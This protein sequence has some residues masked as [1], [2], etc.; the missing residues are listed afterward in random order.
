MRFTRRC[1]LIATAIILIL[2][3]G[4]WL[5]PL[6]FIGRMAWW[7]LV[8][9]TIA[10]FFLLYK[11]KRMVNGHRE[12][13]DRFS[14]GDENQVTLS[15]ESNFSRPLHLEVI[16]EIPVQFQRHDICFY[17]D[18][19]PRGQAVI[20]YQLRPTTRGVYGFGHIR[21]FAMTRLHLVQRRFTCGEPKDIKVYPSYL[22][23]HQYELLAMSNNLHEMGVKRIRRIGHNTDF[24]QIKDYVP[25]DDYRTINWRATARRSLSGL[26]LMVNQYQEERSQPIY[27]VIDKGRMMQ[28]AFGGMT[29]LDYAINAALV[30]SYVAIR[31]EDRAGLVTFCDQ[32]ESF[33]AASRQPGQMRLLQDTLYHEQ[34]KFGES[35]FSA[36]LVGLSHHVSRRSLMVL[37]TSF[38]GLISLR[39]Q[40]PYLR[41]LALRHRLLIVFFEDEE[42]R[43]VN[44]G[45]RVLS[46]EQYYQQV[47]GE[48][49][50]FEQRL[51]TQEL[52]QYGILSL[53]TTPRQLSV[54]V[55]NK[56]LEIKL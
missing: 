33:V 39:R 42:L 4:Y 56:Y 29:L 9:A 10:D 41:Q 46:T 36:L 13:S 52:R 31:K 51:I 44:K 26:R 16:D 40:L 20:H 2:I 6:F 50:A 27:N 28:Q 18:I 37:Y 3:S 49:F 19:I 23:L 14:N 43:N 25:G 12:C 17:T 55:I 32:F 48:K 8:G 34:T 45:Q 24:E 11:R 38:T 22:M 35:D 7:L 15:I 1:Y 53:L 54:D 47:I 30:L 21:I 5:S